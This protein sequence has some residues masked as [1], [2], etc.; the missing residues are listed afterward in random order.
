MAYGSLGS[1]RSAY[2]EEVI[3]R[4]NA[5]CDGYQAT[6]MFRLAKAL[7]FKFPKSSISSMYMFAFEFVS[8]IC[9]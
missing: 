8:S 5:S 6:S 3:D 9:P 2:F 7:G 1:V 4:C